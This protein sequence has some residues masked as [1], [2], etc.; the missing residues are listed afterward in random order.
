MSLSNIYKLDKNVLHKRDIYTTKRGASGA[1]D[2]SFTALDSLWQSADTEYLETMTQLQKEQERVERDTREMLA[3][4]KAQVAEIEKAAYDKGYKAGKEES[5][6]EDQKKQQ[7]ML[8]QF[9]V[10]VQSFEEDR[11][12]L[13]DQYELDILSLVKLMV[14]RVLLH[15]VTVNPQVIEACLKTAM[16]YVVQ[17]SKIKI[18]LHKRDLERLQQ[19]TLDKPELLEGASQVELCEDPTISEGGCYLETGFGEIDATLDSRRETIYKALD[20]IFV[21]ALT[22]RVAHQKEVESRQQ[23]AAQE[24]DVTEI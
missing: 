22:G 18:N 1:D 16:S 21:K 4:A 10:L 23:S 15:E 17:N 9:N 13:H 6:A 5:L 8:A 14:E 3:K 19:A 7:G 24:R 11:K 2:E 20:A 12:R